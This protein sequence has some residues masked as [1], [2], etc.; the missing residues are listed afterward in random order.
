[1]GASVN[2]NCLRSAC[3]AICIGCFLLLFGASI[4]T[5]GKSL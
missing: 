4:A 1:V 2:S 5:M 3:T